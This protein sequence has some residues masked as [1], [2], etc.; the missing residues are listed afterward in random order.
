MIWFKKMVTISVSTWNHPPVRLHCKSTIIICRRIR[1]T[2]KQDGQ[3]WHH[4]RSPIGLIVDHALHSQLLFSY[5][6][7]S[8]GHSSIIFRIIDHANDSEREKF[9]MSS[10]IRLHLYTHYVY[11]SICCDHWRT[12]THSKDYILVQLFLLHQL[13]GLQWR[14]CAYNACRKFLFLVDIFFFHKRVINSEY[15]NKIIYAI[16][17]R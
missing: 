1:P 10:A 17:V 6:I 8:T 5:S 4:K 13:N 16:F 3:R 14:I 7:Y 15:A 9:G 12:V 2:K 11:T